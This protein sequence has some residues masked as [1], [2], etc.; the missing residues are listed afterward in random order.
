MVGF[1]L[2]FHDCDRRK[3]EDQGPAGPSMRSFPL[4]SQ[5]VAERIYFSLILFHSHE[6]TQ[7][8][9]SKLVHA[10]RDILLE[11]IMI[12]IMN[13]KE[14]DY[15]I[16]SFDTVFALNVRGVDSHSSSS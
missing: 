8:A 1:M 12:L 10:E 11:S 6:L 9:T 14:T 13:R 5:T 2:V 15:G 7:P 4:S 3:L 16:S